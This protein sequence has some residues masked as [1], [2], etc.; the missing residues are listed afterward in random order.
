MLDSDPKASGKGALVVLNGEIN[1]AREVTKT[2]TY[3]VEAFQSGQIGLSGYVD[4]DQK[5]QFYRSPV[6]RHTVHSQFSQLSI[7]SLPRI[8]ILYSYVGADDD[9]LQYIVRSGRYQ[10][11]VLAGTGGGHC[12]SAEK[13]SLTDAINHGLHVVRSSRIGDGRVVPLDKEAWLDCITGDNLLPQKARILLMLS[14]LVT[15]DRSVIQ[16]IFDEY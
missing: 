2:N 12:T 1:S 16:Q 4:P 13:D 3:R 14:L 5:V 11:I 7:R 10:G 6:K 15:Q 8:A 9:L